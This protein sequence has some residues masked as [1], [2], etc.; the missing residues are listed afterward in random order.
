MLSGRSGTGQSSPRRRLVAELRESVSLLRAERWVFLG[1]AL[2]W[3]AY[4]AWVVATGYG[5]RRVT[6]WLDSTALGTLGGVDLTATIAVAAV[7]WLVV[8]ALVAVWL[9]NRRL[10]NDYGNLAD[11]YRFDHP[12]LLL[13]VPGTALVCCLVL[14]VAFGR[15]IGLTV[16]AVAATA[17][18]V[19][20]TVAYGHRVYTLSSPAGLSVLVFL[21]ALTFAVGWL[22]TAPD[23]PRVTTWLARAGVDRTAASLLTAIGVTPTLA[24]PAVVAVPGALVAAYLVAQAAA[25]AVVRSRAP[26]ADP[27]RRPDQRFPVMPPVATRDDAPETGPTGAADADEELDHSDSPAEAEE[28]T[29]DIGDAGATRHTGTRVYSPGDS[30]PA[31]PSTASDRGADGRGSD[32]GATDAPT[33]DG[34]RATDGTTDEAATGPGAELERDE[35]PVETGGTADDSNPDEW[36]DDTSVFTPERR[37]GSSERYCPDCGEVVSPDASRCPNCDSR[38]E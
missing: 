32:G 35:Q 3:I 14:S 16:L 33:V 21:T 18:L 10:R 12:A 19:V 36:I 23:V 9:V 26:L 22:A 29:A 37:E 13:V 5:L 8:P 1:L 28:L 25:G 34:V 7:A 6:P 15:S 30:S 11:A 38:A 4:G 27:Q 17:H 24:S 2:A 31:E 20:R